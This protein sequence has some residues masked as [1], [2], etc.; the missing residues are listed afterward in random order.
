MMTAE[1][2]TKKGYHPVTEPYLDEELHMASK[3][4]ADM[5]KGNIPHVMVQED[6]GKAIWRK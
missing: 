4:V 3:V 5:E 2:A 1:Q 6:L